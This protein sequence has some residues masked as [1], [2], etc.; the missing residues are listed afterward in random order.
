MTSVS[1]PDVRPVHL[2]PGEGEA[3]DNPVGG[4]VTFKLRGT[5]TDGAITVFET[6]V[7]PGMGPPLHVHADE[8]EVVYALD[9]AF[10]FSIDG[11][12]RSTPAGSCVFIPRGVAHTWQNIGPGPGRLLAMVAPA[13]LE[14]F[15]D[16]FACSPAEA[17]PQDAFGS[18]GAAAGMLMLG[19][20]LA[21]SHPRAQC[22]KPDPERKPA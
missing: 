22:S 19:P 4:R 17:C 9:G 3:M 20:P 7:A 8:D 11:E 6:V 2:A 5:Q 1:R 12:I 13:G 15:F 14:S 21:R 16:R 18:L 10:R